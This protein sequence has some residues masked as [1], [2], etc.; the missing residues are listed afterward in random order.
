MIVTVGFF[1]SS[2]KFTLPQSILFGGTK[3]LLANDDRWVHKH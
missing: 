1:S 3:K 2:A